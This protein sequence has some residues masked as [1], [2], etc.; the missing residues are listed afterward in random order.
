MNGPFLLVEVNNEIYLMLFCII[1]FY[2]IFRTFL[3][4][5]ELVSALI[6][7]QRTFNFSPHHA[8]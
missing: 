7:P 8:S 4:N 2:S 1:A 6:H 5:Y 3:N